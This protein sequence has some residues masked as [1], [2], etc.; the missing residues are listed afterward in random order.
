[1]AL[2]RPEAVMRDIVT[3]RLAELTP[4]A[5]GVIVSSILR[6]GEAVDVG[7]HGRG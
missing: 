3:M 4:K 6:R 7:Q 2:E 1:V 5:V